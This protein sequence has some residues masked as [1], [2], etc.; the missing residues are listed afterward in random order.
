MKRPIACLVL[1]I[2]IGLLAVRLR[3]CGAPAAP[4]AF[5]T[6][7]V[8]TQVKDGHTTVVAEPNVTTY[9]SQEATVLAGGEAVDP[10]TKQNIPHGIQARVRVRELAPDKLR[11]SMHVSVGD[12][13]A[14][15]D[16]SFVIREWGVHCVRTLAPG[17]KIEIDLDAD[18]KVI[19]SVM[20]VT[21]KK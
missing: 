8:M 20:P 13:D 21:A 14:Q 16:S 19:V 12:L 2:V 9:D 3:A 15:D 10:E 18:R 7:I 17:E 4:K 11:L 5:L 6:T 1:L